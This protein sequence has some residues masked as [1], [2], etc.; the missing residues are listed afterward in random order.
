MPL[1][2]AS[3]IDLVALLNRLLA[4][5]TAGAAAGAVP[6]RSSASTLVA[7]PRSNS[8]LCAPTI[9]RASRACGR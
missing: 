9:R 6:M 2:N 8:V 3:A 1:R 4:K 5:R 7:D